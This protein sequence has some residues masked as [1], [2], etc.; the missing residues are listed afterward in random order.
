MGLCAW[1][2]SD[3]YEG[4]CALR[5][6]AALRYVDTFH[7][8]VVIVLSTETAFD[9]P[10]EQIVDGLDLLTRQLTD[11]GIVVIGVRDSLR[12]S[13]NLLDCSVQRPTTAIFGG[14]LM[15]RREHQAETDPAMALDDIPGFLRI[16]MTDQYCAADICPTVIGNVNVYVDTNHVTAQYQR[17]VAPV[18]VQRVSAA[19]DDLA[20]QGWRGNPRAEDTEQPAEM[21][22]APPGDDVVMDSDLDDE[23]DEGWQ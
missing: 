13:T 4:A 11:R 6:D 2:M 12:S 15:N 8:D 16:D 5:N 20:A 1:G 17:T 22:E 19:L 21:D 10:D 9:S 3:S 23:W 18:F 7:P 14:C